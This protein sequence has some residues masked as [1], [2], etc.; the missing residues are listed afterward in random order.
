M[1]EN[2]FA[3]GLWQ[4]IR[5]AENFATPDFSAVLRVHVAPSKTNKILDIANASGA[6]I[7]IDWAGGLVWLGLPPGAATG[8]TMQRIS[9][10]GGHPMVVKSTDDSLPVLAPANPAIAA[11][12]Q[13][14]KH[15]F[16]PHGIFNPGLLAGH[17]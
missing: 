11:L 13:K 5:N 9:Q 8:E 14:V 7:M 15:A 3:T 17:I 10:S 1:V 16:D 6:S 12:A 2:H 4:R